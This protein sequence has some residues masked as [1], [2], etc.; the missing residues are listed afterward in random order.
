ML[1]V[2][3]AAVEGADAQETKE[4]WPS[5]GPQGRRF[6]ERERSAHR[7]HCMACDCGNLDYTGAS[8]CFRRVEA[9]LEHQADRPKTCPQQHLH[10]ATR[11]QMHHEKARWALVKGSWAPVMG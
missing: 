1:S 8:S 9:C 11:S 5:V 4:T 10:Q 3:R 7:E 2:P 6:S